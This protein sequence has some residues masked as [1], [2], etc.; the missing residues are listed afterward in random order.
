[1]TPRPYLSY[2]QLSL[3]ERSHDKYREVYLEGGESFSNRA[4][5]FGSQVADSLERDEETGDELSDLVLA[6]FPKLARRDEMLYANIGKGK[7]QVPV[8]AKIDSASTDWLDDIEYKTG[9]MK[10]TQ[11]KA[12]KSDQI[13]FYCMVVWL[14]TGK[15]P[16]F[17][18]VWGPT[19]VIDGKVRFTGAHPVIFNTERHM[20]EILKMMGRSKSAWAQI[21]AMTDKATI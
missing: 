2:S 3:L 6:H 12:D 17:R 13:T 20:S 8:V 11:Q 21:Q 19:E 14:A 4:M 10:W 1:M 7:N 9:S 18:L 15:I 16:R 5:A